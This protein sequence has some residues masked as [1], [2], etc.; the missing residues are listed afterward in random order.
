M[1]HVLYYMGHCRDVNRK[2]T[3]V[4]PHNPFSHALLLTG[5]FFLFQNGIIF[6]GILFCMILLFV[7]VK[8]TEYTQQG[9]GFLD[10]YRVCEETQP[11][12]WS[13][14]D[15]IE[16]WT[17]FSGLLFSNFPHL[18]GSKS[19]VR[20]ASCSSINMSPYKPLSLP[21]SRYKYHVIFSPNSKTETMFGLAWVRR[22]FLV[23]SALLRVRTVLG[24]VAIGWRMYSGVCGV[25][26]G[27][28]CF[29]GKLTTITV[30]SAS[31]SSLLVLSIC[32]HSSWDVK[33]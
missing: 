28:G 14:Q 16:H 2:D 31:F 3:C 23:Q 17:V 29:W 19:H 4:P 30:R 13:H 8:V 6:K 21:Q 12:S 9:L 27:G 20:V 22:P 7:F 32:L 26:W 10:I 5:H 15:P 11:S 25:F 33:F 24:N 18:L 1:A